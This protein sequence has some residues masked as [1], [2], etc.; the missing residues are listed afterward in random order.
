MQY[1][2]VRK[3]AINKRNNAATSK[4]CTTNAKASHFKYE[5]Y[6]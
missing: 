4:Y 6:L 3:E 1:K 2:M 5:H